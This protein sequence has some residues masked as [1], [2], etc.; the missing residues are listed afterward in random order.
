MRLPEGSWRVQKKATRKCTCPRCAQSAQ[1]Q[2]VASSW[3]PFPSSRVVTP[4]VR[5]HQ[6]AQPHAV[7]GVP[8]GFRIP[9]NVLLCAPTGAGKPTS[10]VSRCFERLVSIEG[11]TAPLTRA[12]SRWCTSHPEG[13]REG[14][15]RD[16]HQVAGS[17][18]DGARAVG[19][20]AL[21]RREISETQ[22]IDYPGEVGHRLARA[23]AHAPSP[24][25][26]AS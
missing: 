17:W 21:S 10:P 25:S 12:P 14:G 5:H 1:P 6:E 23:A 9:E 18:P 26:S 4:S 8:D 24:N 15:R 20:N 19:D 11:R 16:L 2:V 22:L 7:N 13:S 3:S